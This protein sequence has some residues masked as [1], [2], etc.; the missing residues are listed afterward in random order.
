MRMVTRDFRSGGLLGGGLA[1]RTVGAGEQL[2]HDHLG[3]GIG[4]W[5]G[6]EPR[7]PGD[8]GEHTLHPLR[9]GTH[10]HI[11]QE[12]RNVRAGVEPE[13]RLFATDKPSVKQV[14]KA[15]ASLSK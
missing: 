14:R 4:E 9:D 13:A 6:V 11:V 2:E 8:E 12:A 1:L 5:A 10:I 3:S 7:I 15:A